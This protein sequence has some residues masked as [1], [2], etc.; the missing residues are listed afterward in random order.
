[1]CQ[2]LAGPPRHRPKTC[3]KYTSHQAHWRV[4]LLDFKQQLRAPNMCCAQPSPA[5]TAS[6]LN[7]NAHAHTH[8][9]TP[10]GIK[11]LCQ[12]PTLDVVGHVIRQVAARVRLAALTVAEQE[13]VVVASGA[14][15]VQAGRV[16]LLSLTTKPCTRARAD[17]YDITGFKGESSP[18]GT[19]TRQRSQGML[20]PPQQP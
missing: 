10:V 11:R 16:L 3:Q 20:A 14:E 7:P 19:H 15:Q 17:M 8:P 4:L 5:A 9:T 1:M 12:P 13:S 18:L 2:Q 6:T